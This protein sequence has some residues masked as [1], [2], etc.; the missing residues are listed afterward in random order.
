MTTL[1]LFVALVPLVAWAVHRD[2]RRAVR[3]RRM[4]QLTEP[5]R[6]S[7]LGFQAAIAAA[8]LPTMVRAAADMEASLRK[9]SEAMS[10]TPVTLAELQALARKVR[11]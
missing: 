6:R 3:R 11:R 5:L 2:I 7:L 4:R 9:V 10:A 1:V 8:M